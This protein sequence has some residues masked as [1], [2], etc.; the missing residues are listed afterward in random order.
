MHHQDPQARPV[1]RKSRV[2][3]LAQLGGP[4]SPG[5][6]DPRFELSGILYP[7]RPKLGSP[8]SVFRK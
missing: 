2:A 4:G 3:D 8:I 1:S 6:S 7:H 5:Q